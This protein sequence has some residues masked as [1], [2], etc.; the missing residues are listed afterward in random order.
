MKP[1][2]KAVNQKLDELIALLADNHIDSEKARGLRQRISKAIEASSTEEEEKI[3]AFRSLDTSNASRLELLDEF[4]ILLSSNQI[5]SN[6]S[7][8][9]IATHSTNVLVIIIGIVMITL[10][11]AMIIMPAPPDF[12]IYT[13]FY[14]NQNDGVTIM[15]LISLLIVLAG[16]YL[17]IKSVYKRSAGI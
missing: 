1:D 7:K 14:F 12:E 5:D 2:D 4:S 9:Y 8:K 11:F 6:T 3:D 16:I 17:L 15:D 10:G 13:V